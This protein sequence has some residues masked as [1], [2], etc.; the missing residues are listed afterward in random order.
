[1]E[2]KRP[3]SARNTPL[4]L[5]IGFHNIEGLHSDCECLLDDIKDHINKDIM[6]LAETW[7]CEHTKNLEGY[8]CFYEPGYKNPGVTSGRASGGM[9]VYVKNYIKNFVKILQLNPYSCFLELDK[10]ISE[11]LEQNLI[12]SAH[13]SPPVNSKYHH[14]NSCDTIQNDILNF[15]DQNTPLILIGNFNARTG[16]VPD[17]IEIDPNFE[18]QLI[19]Q[20]D[21]K[22]RKN[23]DRTI[24]SQGKIF[25]E[26]LKTRDLRILN[27]R[28]PGDI[29]GNFTTFKNGHTSVNDY[30][31]VSQNFFDK[32]ENFLV[33]PQT[34]YSD[35]A[36]ITITIKSKIDKSENEVNGK[37]NCK[38]NWYTLNK[39]KNWDTDSLSKLNES[40]K[41]NI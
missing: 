37:N 33:H 1:M 15:C 25:I 34:T 5:S 27:G 18:S 13:Y 21:F 31:I 41:K 14:K 20:S 36:P 7:T 30:G 28:F 3:T 24:T 38:N 12:V 29:L 11:N 17:N 32:I 9:L 40:L 19:T 6:F 35:H 23:L 2:E 4:N 8:Q 22:P 16:D 26:T 39:R 10:Q